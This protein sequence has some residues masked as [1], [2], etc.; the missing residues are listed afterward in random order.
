MTLCLREA[1][2]NFFPFPVG[3]RGACCWG[4]KGPRFSVFFLI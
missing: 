3:R 1:E 4:A 2:A